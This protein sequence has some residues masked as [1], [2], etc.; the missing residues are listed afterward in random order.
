[1][2]PLTALLLSDGKPGHY[3]Q[4]EGVL[5]ALARLRSLKSVRLEVRRRLLIPTRTL[6]QLINAG[7]P[8]ALVLW[9]G[10]GVRPL[11]LPAVDVVVSAGGETLAAN[12]AAARLAGAPN[13]FCGR[14]RRLAPRHVRVV[15]VAQEGLAAQPNHLLALPPSPIEA[16]RSPRPA[17]SPHLGRRNPPRLACVLVGGNSGAFTYSVQD[18]TGLIAFMH[19]T[20]CRHGLRWVATTSRR[21]GP[22]IGDAL[23]RMAGQPDSGLEQF[24]DYRTA[25]P[26]AVQD[27][28]AA[29]DAV[30]CTDDSTTMISEAVGAQLPV[31]AVRPETSRLEE[32]EREYRDF[33]AHQGWYRALPISQLGPDSF[34]AAL[35]EIS[36]RTTSPIDELA[37]ALRQRLPELICDSTAA[38]KT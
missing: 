28:F 5:A 7:A 12:A 8:P 14:L 9:L 11:V 33:L 22:F 25:G 34:L 19:E 23:A 1:M 24:V 15:I 10:Y 2:P 27:I 29:V 18:W 32:R 36:P 21:S 16:R 13:I 17:G 31:V 4:A 30:V 3:H 38:Q 26:G 37:A 35:E 6:L 20:H